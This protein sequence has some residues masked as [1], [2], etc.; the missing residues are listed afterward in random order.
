M[1]KNSYYYFLVYLKIVNCLVK[2]DELIFFEYSHIHL[3]LSKLY[4]SLCR[5]LFLFF[6]IYLFDASLMHAIWSIHGTFLFQVF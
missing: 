4:K 5:I 2:F 6:F 1:F 3:S